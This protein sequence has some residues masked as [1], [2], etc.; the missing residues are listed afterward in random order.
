ME[1]K[2]L[3][4]LWG[5]EHIEMHTFLNKVRKAGY[6]G[7]ETWLPDD[8]SDQKLLFDYLQKHE[9]HFVCHQYEANGTTFKKFRADYIKR[10][11]A[12]SLEAPLLI[13]SHTGKDYFTFEQNL[14]LVDAATE[15]SIRTGIAVV[16]ETHRGR[17][18]YCPQSMEA[19]FRERQEFFI[20]ADFSHW[21]CVTESMLENFGPTLKQAI[22]RS[23]YI[24][25]RVGYEEGPQI[26]DPRATEWQ[27]AVTKFLD[28]WDQVI[29]I[30][31]KLNP[32][33]FP[34]TTEFGPFPY[35][36]VSPFSQKPLADQFE[37]NCYMKDLLKE[38]Y[39]H[40]TPK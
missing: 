16:H 19:F 32:T 34:I 28:W 13:N 6:D 36:A 8:L 4:P 18:G 11:K 7:V 39:R 31:I 24:H 23:R 20:T 10:L 29:A 33:I 3:S 21:V 2:I 38:R 5:H 37:I 1:V 22:Q 27:Y 40:L 15:F 30:N 9:M 12:C 17:L 25:A 35:M 26:T 14:A